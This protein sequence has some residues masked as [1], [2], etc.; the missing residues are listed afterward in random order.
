M[1]HVTP[2]QLRRMIPPA[3]VAL[4]DVLGD[5]GLLALVERYG[6][7]RLSVPGR[8]DQDAPLAQVLP[9]EQARQLVERWGPTT[10]QIALCK[11][12]RI[13][14]LR[15]RRL[16]YDVVARRVGVSQKTVYREM[17]RDRSTFGSFG[18]GMSDRKQLG[19]KF[20]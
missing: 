12:W 10:L 17:G 5:D 11:T 4:H 20:D 3:M 9:I 18:A 19:F 14:L 15:Q 7:T 13:H 16:S 1:P 6:G 8:L 2:E